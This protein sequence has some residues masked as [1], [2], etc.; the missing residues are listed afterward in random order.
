VRARIGRLPALSWIGAGFGALLLAIGLWDARHAEPSSAIALDAVA[1]GGEFE[2]QSAL[3]LSSHDLLKQ[4]PELLAE[5]VAAVHTRMPVWILASHADDIPRA[6]ALFEARGVD[7]ARVRF[8]AAPVE[9]MWVRDYGP[10]V[11]RSSEGRPIALD[12]DHPESAPEQA[13]RAGDDSV[14][15]ELARVLGIESRAVP[16]RLGAGNL[17]SNGDGLVVSTFAAV[18]DNRER[19]LDAR[20]MSQALAREIAMREWLVLAPLEGEPTHDADMFLSFPAPDLALVG[21]FDPAVDAKNAAILDEAAKL[22]EGRATSRG[23]L[24]VRRIPMPPSRGEVWRSYTNVLYANGILL[25]PTFADVDPA[26]EAE[27]LR[28]WREALP[29]WEVRG[30]RTDALAKRFGLLH[31]LSQALPGYVALERVRER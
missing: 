4:Q 27:A 13:P 7:P 3:I 19:G 15:R 17:L 16:L 11:G 21:Y 24:R 10:I 14:P 25:V 1:L 6:G 12:F 31:C 30:L 8:V 23:P 28:V 29:D 26:L 18:L 5:I 22:L 20:A 2:P 9:T